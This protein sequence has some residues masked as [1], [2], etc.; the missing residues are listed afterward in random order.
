MGSDSSW[1]PGC[2]SR[3]DRWLDIFALV[4]YVP[5]PLGR[6]L[7]DLSRELTPGS[8]PRAHVSVLPP[9]E[10][11][12][13]W[14]AGREQARLLAEGWAPF[15]IEATGIGLFP[16]TEVVY[17]E[18]GAGARELS[19]LHGLLNSHHLRF[20]ERFEYHP[21]ITLAQEI[22]HDDVG[23]ALELAERRWREYPG[24]RSFLAER[25][26]FVRN[27]L[28]HQWFDLAELPL[29]AAGARLP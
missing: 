15:G 2:P 23:R 25:A 4:I 3:E 27:S 6:F 12:H 22:P 20:A 14:E 18:L 26:F 16:S 21:H 7:D 8:N 28:A 10:F 11:N 17:L 13:G 1:A 24:P 19:R 29:G 5:D 9:R